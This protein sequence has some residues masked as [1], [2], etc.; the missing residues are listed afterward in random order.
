MDTIWTTETEA[1]KRARLRQQL[2]EHPDVFVGELVGHGTAVSIEAGQETVGFPA[3]SQPRPGELRR[4][5]RMLGAPLPRPP[6]CSHAPHTGVGRPRSSL[7]PGRPARRGSTRSTRA[8]PSGADD[9]PPAAEPPDRPSKVERLAQ[10][11]RHARAG[12]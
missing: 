12:L 11:L 10:A 9:P 6:A 8:G 4:A 5:A 3:H 1:Q 7:R 2:R